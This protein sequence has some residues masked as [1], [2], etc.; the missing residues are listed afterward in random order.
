MINASTI[1]LTGSILFS[2]LIC[3]IL[4]GRKSELIFVNRL[5]A[6][7]FLGYIWYA[8]MILLGITDWIKKV[9][10]LFGSGIPLYYTAAVF[11]YLYVRATINQ[12]RNFLKYD[13]LHFLP[14]I[15]SFIAVMPFYISDNKTKLNFIDLVYRSDRAFVYSKVGFLP[16]NWNFY[17]R[18]LQGLIYTTLEWLQIFSFI[19]QAPISKMAKR[20]ILIFTIL[21]TVTYLNLSIATLN[22]VKNVTSYRSNF[23]M[24]PTAFIIGAIVFF[25]L[26]TYLFFYPEILYGKSSSE[27]IPILYTLAKPAIVPQDEQDNNLVG[28][29]NNKENVLSES[30]VLAYAGIIENH[31][32]TTSFYRRRYLTQKDLSE[33]INISPR[34]ISYVLNQHFNKRFTEYINDYRIN[35]LKTRIDNNDWKNLTL[36]GLAN[37]AGFSSRNTFSLAFKKNLGI[38]PS[39]YIDII[40]S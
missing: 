27:K 29:K 12:Q 26:S 33:E 39:E 14:S 38:T 21:Q 2:A 25:V 16:N 19:K 5:L 9:P 8:F 23:N 15:L 40:K 34:N 17:L 28:Y 7:A 3:T 37:E 36:E 31:M 32:A 13:W 22:G 6:G 11:S 30:L 1:F 35:Y 18:P 24:I 4:I 10:F 20:W